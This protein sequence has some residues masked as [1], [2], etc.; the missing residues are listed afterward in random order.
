MTGSNKYMVRS[1][2][3]HKTI[4]KDSGATTSSSDSDDVEDSLLPSTSSSHL[5]ESSRR[6]CTITSSNDVDIIQYRYYSH[7]IN[8]ED[9]V[10][11]VSE[12]RIHKMRRRRDSSSH[13][14]RRRTM[15]STSS[16]C[17]TSSSAPTTSLSSLCRRTASIIFL[18]LSLCAIFQPCS[19]IREIRCP[20][21]DIR[22]K[23]WGIKTR[24][25]L[26]G[27]KDQINYFYDRSNNA[28]W[29]PVN[30]MINCTVIEGSLSLSFIYG[31]GHSNDP[32]EMKN[33]E[34]SDYPIFPNLREVTG[35]FL[36]FET[37]GLVDLGKMF[38]QLRVIGG[39]TLVQHF[40]LIIYRNHQLEAINLP[41]L[42]VVRNGGIRV[43]DNKYCCHVTSIDWKSLIQSPINDVVVD[44]AAEWSVTETGKVCPKTC[45]TEPNYKDRC[46][47][48]M[49]PE[50]K[51]VQSCWS[52]T[53]C[54]RKCP[55]ER[56]D[57]GTMGPG[58]SPEGE[59]CHEQCLG[60]CDAPNDDTQ[61]SA[62]RH[63]HYN[64][65]C[66]AKCP[67]NMYVLM[68]RR[69]VTKAECLAL[70]PKQK[71]IFQHIK[72]T[73]GL[74]S[75]KCPEGW[76]IN[77]K[78][79]RFCKK[80][81]GP[82]EITCTIDHKIDTF[83]KALAL[84]R[85]N[86]IKGNLTIE[87][88]G[89][90][91]S[92]MA[93]EL[94]EVFANIHTITEYLHIMRSP[95]LLSL[96]MFKRLKLIRG[97][98]LFLNKFAISVVE[99]DNM[100][101]LFE[102]NRE[103]VF[104]NKN[105][106]V[107][108]HNNRMLC[109]ELITDLT[110]MLGINKTH[111]DDQ[112][113]NSNGDK[114][115]CATSLITVKLG[116]VSDDSI[117]F[118]WAQL[119]LTD[120]DFRKFLGY[121]LFYKEV[122]KIDPKMTIDDDRSACVDSWSS[123]FIQHYEDGKKVIEATLLA[124]D[125]IRPN[126]LYAYY[127]AT[128]MV[129]HPGARN[130]ISKIGFVR[131]KY[132]VPDPP[133]VR[134]DAVSQNSI[135]LVWDPPHHSNGD[136][137]FYTISWRE[138]DIDVHAEAMRFCNEEGTMV[139]TRYEDD[140]SDKPDKEVSISMYSPFT[141]N[142][143]CSASAGCCACSAL[144]SSDDRSLTTP[145]PDKRQEDANFE[146]TLIDTLFA[147]AT[148]HGCDYD[149]DPIG[150][151]IRRRPME[152]EVFEHETPGE[153][154]EDVEE[155]LRVKRNTEALE[156][157]RQAI[158]RGEE[159]G[160]S[161]AIRGA[162]IDDE[163]Y[164]R[165][166]ALILANIREKRSIQNA[167]EQDE[168]LA[169]KE[170]KFFKKSPETSGQTD[171]PNEKD[172]DIGKETTD[173]EI[174]RLLA[175]DKQE[176][177]E[178]D[179][180][181]NSTVAP[182]AK[183]TVAVMDEILYPANVNTIN[184]TAKATGNQWLLGNL[185]HYTIYAITIQACQNTS[186]FPH[187]CSVPHK[188][189]TKKRTL[190]KPDIDKVDQSTIMTI[191]D[192]QEPNKVHIT[193]NHPD[194]TNGGV[195]GYMVTVKNSMEIPVCV[196]NTK[197][198]DPTTH[199]TVFR[200]LSEGS[201]E[202]G[203]VTYSAASNGERVKRQAMYEVSMPSFWLWWRLLLVGLFIFCL[204]AAIAG[205]VY[206]NVRYKFGKRVKKLADFMHMNPEYCVD[207]KYTID[208]WELEKESVTL[209]EVIGQGTFGKV[210]LAQGKKCVSIRGDAFGPCAV[211]INT[212]EA[213]ES[214]ENMNYLMEAN[215]MKNFKTT[216][217]VKLFGVVSSVHP[218]WVVMEF[219][220]LGNLR[221]YLRAKRE[222]EVFDENN[223]NFYN[224]VPREKICEWAA[225]ICDGMAYL[226][227]LKFCHRDLAARNCMIDKT[228]LVKIGDFGMAR[229]L[230]YHDYYKPSGKRMMPVRW[231]SPESLKDGKFDSKSD[232]W[233]FGVV[234]YELITLGAQPYIGLSNDEVLNY[235]GMAR[236]V[237][238]KP[239]CCSEYWYK[240]MKMCWRY[241]P[242]DRPTFLQ[243][244][245]LLS[246][247]ASE[248]F[249]TLSFVFTENQMAM[250]D[251]EPLDLDEIYNYNPPEELDPA[252]MDAQVMEEE[253]KGGRRMTDSIPMKEFKSDGLR[254]NGG[255]TGGGSSHS[256]ISMGSTMIPMKPKRR[257]GS[258]DEEYTLMNH[259]RGPSDTEIRT[260]TGDEGDYVERD[261][262][263][264][265]PTRRNTGA[266]NC[267]Y[268]GGPYCLTNRGGSNERAGFGEGLRLT[269]GVGSGGHLHEDSY[270][271]D[272]Q[273]NSMDTRRSTGASTASYGAPPQTK[274][275][276]SQTKGATYFE[277]QKQ[278]QA[279]AEA[280][281]KKA[282]LSGVGDH[283]VVIPTGFNGDP[284]Y[285]ET[286]PPLSK[287]SPS[288]NGNTGYHHHGHHGPP[289]RGNGRT[290][291]GETERLIEEHP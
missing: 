206:Y 259:S 223:C 32:R 228:E 87:I 139:A 122:D 166:S 269:D 57:N 162:D 51:Q 230:F 9:N 251:T 159:E 104:G 5:E 212:E 291:F 7:V 72:A 143:T 128:Q 243:L 135:K 142:D 14:T 53:A 160:Q 173:E 4:L 267:S 129:R 56:F 144:A 271:S 284:D 124:K 140:T 253:R 213:A 282:K 107:Q 285:T 15:I 63:L 252:A 183:P 234:L 217:I 209:G 169:R 41:K 248:E 257:Q 255:G 54:R 277:K 221:D 58:C 227:S 76:E 216:F 189:A 202:I 204:I 10:D 11:D 24:P 157:R 90:Q 95:P 177:N 214:L 8:N 125:R 28:S 176:Q 34:Q 132:A 2:R 29:P 100:R 130:G 97:D 82:C 37:K 102:D 241:A 71:N 246:A 262:A 79:I 123:V 75:D 81:D 233:S 127:V 151:A 109:F 219:M 161:H 279:A 147:S 48:Y 286:E 184:V 203:I 36:V 18:L 154:A 66:V 103:I 43:Q 270:Y 137:T 245:H 182:E 99:N 1:R 39:Q 131:T 254:K 20:P 33:L 283:P 232:I 112:S 199:G 65:K 16:E 174:K 276:G 44:D 153:D 120:S 278:M 96:A 181:T 13:R 111:D 150:C 86:I 21:I 289:H 119:D 69:C 106:T 193:W 288:K 38:P 210:Y 191:Q 59:R 117:H 30:H 126:T 114:A 98:T 186:N 240:I 46:R 31:G 261:V 163:Q 77:K 113:P 218:A 156:R 85:C 25:S 146:N 78:D 172:Q 273:L 194:E 190:A 115:I 229:D 152:S 17:S 201:Y 67:K 179:S 62:C 155:H 23:P 263:A 236:K 220:E 158:L 200:D 74:C 42:S 205:V 61:C 145:D 116:A 68:G 235:I 281:A 224:I 136:I 27:D 244:V 237:I 242:R 264:D 247:E 40:A 280:A 55:Y 89:K 175:G 49:T 70:N 187:Y 170:K 180:S 94:K 121:E 168:M 287:G 80:C 165:F 197:G 84:R 258:L 164:E 207:N 249:K 133:M 134:V 198:F 108:F 266:S 52:D 138:L 239:D 208:D 226:E 149:A 118:S 178:N 250:E 47:E 50:G 105:A 101:S 272:N 274:W 26:I 88:R 110:K 22:N 171:T 188:A 12:F 211:K 60:G 185:K 6:N 73:D 238:K 141:S 93:A 231:M 195:L 192:K 265:V 148:T 19:S 290:A 167:K 45:D 91:E 64:G 260:Y 222:E 256:T 83:P 196:P 35:T 92:G 3:R 215:V 225:Q 275:S 268:T